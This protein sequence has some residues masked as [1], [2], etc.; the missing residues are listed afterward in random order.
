M[1][2]QDLVHATPDK[3]ST[4]TQDINCENNSILREIVT[5]EKFTLG[6]KMSVSGNGLKAI[7]EWF[8]FE[9]WLPGPL[10]ALA[11]SFTHNSN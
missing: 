1:R 10:A 7:S 5:G 3:T 9:L 6:E 2:I 11:S 8:D 4:P